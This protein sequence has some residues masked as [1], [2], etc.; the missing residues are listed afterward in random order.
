M[1]RV[2]SEC[3]TVATNDSMAAHTK[4]VSLLESHGFT[5]K[6]SKVYL[7]LLHLGE[8]PASAIARKAGI[9]RPTAYVALERLEA[10]GIVAHVTR[11]RGLFFRAVSPHALLDRSH[12]RHAALQSALPE[13]DALSKTGNPRPQMSVFEG[14]DGIQGIM[15]DT[16]SSRTEI[17]YWADMTTIVTTVFKDYWKTYVRK[18]VAKGIRTRGIVCADAIGLEFKRRG[19]DELRESLLV[20]K[21]RFPF[22]NEINIYDDKVAIISHADLTGVIIQNRNMADTQRTIFE[23]GY[24]HARAL[25]GEITRSLARAHA[26]G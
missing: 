25:D 6:E 3:L 4:L 13:L 15:E 11:S 5:D 23:L 7:A 12:S 16:L 22:R 24:E 18:R 19:R 17:L 1:M 10:S 8:A 21:E 26:R 2:L 9:K 20:P 14:K